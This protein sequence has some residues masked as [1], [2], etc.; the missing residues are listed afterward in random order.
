M[1]EVLLR[2]TMPAAGE[3]GARGGLRARR[4]RPRRGRARRRR[5]RGRPDRRRRGD[6]G[7]GRA[8]GGRPRA[9][10]DQD[11]AADA[12]ALGEP[13]GAFDVALSRMGLMLLPDP[14]RAAAELARVLRAGGRAAVAVWGSRAANPWLGVLLDAV[15]AELGVEVPPPGVPGPFSLADPVRTAGAPARR[16]L[17]RRRR[18]RGR[19]ALPGGVG[20][21][22]VG[23]GPRA[24]RPAGRA[25]RRAATG[26]GRRHPR[27]RGGGDLRLRGARRRD[28]GART[29]AR[30]RR[31]PDGLAGP[32]HPA[33]RDARARG[34]DGSPVTP[35]GVRSSAPAVATSRWSASK[36]TELTKSAG[37]SSRATSAPSAAKRATCA[38]GPSATQT[39]PSASTARPSGAAPA[40]ARANVR[41]PPPCAPAATTSPAAKSLTYSV[42]PSGESPTPLGHSSPPRTTCGGCVAGSPGGMRH[43]APGTGASPAIGRKHSAPTSTPPASSVTRSL[44]PVTPGGGASSTRRRGGRHGP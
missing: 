35:T 34:R 22:V 26:D 10:P 9:R 6:D 30:R 33:R 15:G 4:R 18:R 24:G 7:G 5:R 20:G 36:A 44:K 12:E 29:R 31:D 43:S 8:A 27:P 19:A 40:G 2:R 21:R 37:T 42:A 23:G 11:R 28:R 14:A 17:R 1:T 16:G 13:D 39:P 32:A 25:P 41:R 3:R 38:A